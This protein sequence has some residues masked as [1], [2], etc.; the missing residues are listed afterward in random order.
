M[1][2]HIDY[3]PS[4]LFR[5]QNECFKSKCTLKGIKRME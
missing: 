1:T 2:N 4:V 3:T 5:E